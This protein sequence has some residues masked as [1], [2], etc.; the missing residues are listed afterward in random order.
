[1]N[2]EDQKQYDALYIAA[3]VQPGDCIEA[4]HIRYGILCDDIRPRMYGIVVPPD[5]ERDRGGSG[6]LEQYYIRFLQT[7]RNFIRRG[8]SYK[9]GC[10]LPEWNRSKPGIGWILRKMHPPR[11]LVL[12]LI[13]DAEPQ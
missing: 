10:T 8:Y 2:A 6:D 9:A 7:D 3:G 4:R 5:P 13:P 1:M 12:P 11:Q